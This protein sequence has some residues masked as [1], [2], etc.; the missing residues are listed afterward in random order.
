MFLFFIL[1]IIRWYVSMFTPSSLLSGP[2]KG[3]HACRTL[4]CITLYSTG[5]NTERIVRYIIYSGC[6]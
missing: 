4:H 2:T 6:C 3:I 1:Y 5:I